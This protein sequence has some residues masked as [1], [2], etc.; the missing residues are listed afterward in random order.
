MSYSMV[1]VE[2]LYVPDWPAGSWLSKYT[3]LITKITE[4]IETNDNYSSVTS[5]QS[6]QVI[7]CLPLLTFELSQL[8]FGF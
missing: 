3:M 8:E 6:F 5:L 1:T 4:V 7:T 2:N